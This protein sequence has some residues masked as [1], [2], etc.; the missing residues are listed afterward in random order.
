MS[1]SAS[2]T[3]QGTDRQTRPE[4]TLRT[5]AEPAVAVLGPAALIPTARRSAEPAGEPAL[6]LARTTERVRP[7]TIP[8]ARTAEPAL[9]I[10]LP[11]PARVE[12]IA[13]VTLPAARPAEPAAEPELPATPSSPA[14]HAP[15]PSFYSRRGKRALDLTTALAVG[16]ASLPLQLAVALLVRVKLGSPVLFHQER[17]GLD[18][19]TFKLI[20]FRTMTDAKDP[21]GT[22]LSD[23]VRL[24]RFG[25]LLRSTSIDELPE[26]LNVIKGEMSLVGPRPLM[27][28][29]L[30]RYSPDQARR[31]EVRPGITGWAQVHGR[32]NL[33]WPE[34]LAMDTWYVDHVSL[35]LDLSI[36]WQTVRAVIS[37]SDVAQDGHA[38][39]EDFMGEVAISAPGA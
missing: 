9:P 19:R 28:E 24:T 15:R 13:P 31:H 7:I 35:R 5:E 34:R 26:I 25:E 23:E 33:P 30:S 17:P 20:K 32:N 39:M 12:P 3:A 36:L 2:N 27:V 38:T 11:A 1:N 29:Y 16:V 37:R 4:I 18:G 10:T 14:I 22:L 21:A 6:P 8:A